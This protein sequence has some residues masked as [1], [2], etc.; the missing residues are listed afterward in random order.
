MRLAQPD[1]LMRRL[2]DQAQLPV[3]DDDPA[4]FDGGVQIDRLLC[5]GRKTG[6]HEQ[7]GQDVSDAH[8]TKLEEGPAT[9]FSAGTAG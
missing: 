9:S 7:C 4:L 6:Q 1:A 3:E 8:A 5:D 2:I